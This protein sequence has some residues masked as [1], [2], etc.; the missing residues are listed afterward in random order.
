MPPA[1]SSTYS[2]GNRVGDFFRGAGDI[3]RGARLLLARP[4]LWPWAI[5]PFILNVLIFGLAVW[6]GVH[7][8]GGWIE[9]V[10]TGQGFWIDMLRWAIKLILWLAIGLIV[11]FLF[12]PVASLI[13]A[14]FNDILSEKVEKIYSGATV[15]GSFSPRALARA[16]AVGMHTSIKLS[17]MTLGMLACSLLL[18]FI[19]PPVGPAAANIASA[20][21]TIRF[22]SLQFTAYSMDR[23]FYNYAQ[24]R[25]F[26]RHHRARTI[27]LGAMAF[28]IMLV[29]VLNALFIPVSAIAG[30]LLFCDT[31]L[32][33]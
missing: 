1:S 32:R 33:K 3:W 10:L 7:F 12:V 18:Y 14:P 17:L 11:I 23:R 15:E 22:L 19:P 5:I 2:S 9:H 8:G 6:A 4:G 29:P 28:L 25:D 31:Q 21:I 20:A 16:L 13:A 26:L 30:T 27:G 24:R